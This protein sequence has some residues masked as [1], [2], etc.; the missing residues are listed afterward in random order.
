MLES[1]FLAGSYTP[2]GCTTTEP[3]QPPMENAK[4]KGGE[5]RKLYG[6]TPQTEPKKKKAKKEDNKENTCSSK[7]EKHGK[8]K[9]KQTKRK[10]AKGR[11]N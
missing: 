8:K 4:P 5:K 1:R 6:C 2:D 11:L 10:K 7:S 9:D 3:E